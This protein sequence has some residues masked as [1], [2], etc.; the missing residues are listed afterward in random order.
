MGK[1]IKCGC[2]TKD[3]ALVY[4]GT[5]A[6]AEDGL[7]AC[8]F[9]PHTEY[10]CRACVEEYGRSGGKTSVLFYLAL[11]MCWLTVF[12]SGL[13][14]PVGLF[15][16]AVGVFSAV[17]LILILGRLVIRRRKPS[18]T[19]QNQDADAS[20]L[21][22]NLIRRD[23]SDLGNAVLSLKEYHRRFRNE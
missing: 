23:Q 18:G 2:D 20:E 10:L 15:A 21:C 8:R 13:S 6:M 12:K 17:R 7:S 9:A 14:S 1:C 5:P 19:S 4:L 3:T 16:A 11:Q 22:R